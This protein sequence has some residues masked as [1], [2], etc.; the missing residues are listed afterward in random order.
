MNKLAY[1]LKVPFVGSRLWS[2]RQPQRGE[3]VVFYRFSEFEQ[4]D[5][6]KH[7]IKRI[8]AVPADVVEVRHGLTYVNN[9]PTEYGADE[10]FAMVPSESSIQSRYG[11]VKLKPGEYFVLGDNRS[12]SKDSRYFGPIHFSDIEGRAMFVYWS[13]DR[14]RGGLRI[15]WS[16]I[17]KGIS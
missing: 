6:D 1:G 4:L 15:R 9:Q 8:A 7:Y 11:P 5:I 12:N 13:T 10:T 2:R 14:D 17:G 16:R 3:I